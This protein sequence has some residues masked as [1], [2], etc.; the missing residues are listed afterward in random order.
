MG[1][2]LKWSFEQQNM[3]FSYFYINNYG[4]TTNYKLFL[5]NFDYL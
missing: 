5:K 3:I 4:D 1:L 2:G